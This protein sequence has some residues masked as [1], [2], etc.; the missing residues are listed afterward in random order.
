MEGIIAPRHRDLMQT[1]DEKMK[2]NFKRET[3]ANGTGHQHHLISHL[4]KDLL[5]IQ[6]LFTFSIDP[7]QTRR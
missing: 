1:N 3:M 4:T 5:T 7:H 2:I 6:V